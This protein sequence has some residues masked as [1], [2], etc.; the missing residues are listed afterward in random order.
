[1]SYYVSNT[2]VRIGAI[3]AVLLILM[4]F[5]AGIVFGV[6]YA[7]EA[8]QV[9]VGTPAFHSTAEYGSYQVVLEL[10]NNQWIHLS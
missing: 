10:M 4:G 2:K 6:C 8:V 1:M 5:A 3:I 9:S 7:M